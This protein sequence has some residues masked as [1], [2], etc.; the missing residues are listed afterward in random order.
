MLF[1]RTDVTTCL[2]LDTQNPTNKKNQ[3]QQLPELAT[4]HCFQQSAMS[5]PGSDTTHA[6]KEL[7]PNKYFMWCSSFHF[8]LEQSITGGVTAT[9]TQS[10][11]YVLHA[12]CHAEASELPSP[13][14]NDL[15]LGYTNCL[16]HRN[17]PSQQVER[18]LLFP[19]SLNIWNLWQYFHFGN[20]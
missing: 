19:L 20:K 4:T 7:V 3:P 14:Y 1:A 18:P 10:Q 15:Q 11:K 9:P 16:N 8:H 5:S 2:R 13:G 6:G 17:T 12:A